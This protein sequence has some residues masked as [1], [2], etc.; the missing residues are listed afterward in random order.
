[1][2]SPIRYEYDA[3]VAEYRKIGFIPAV[4]LLGVLFGIGVAMPRTLQYFGV[5][6]QPQQAQLS[7]SEKKPVELAQPAVIENKGTAGPEI[8]DG[9]LESLLSQWEAAHPDKDWSVAVQRLGEKPTSAYL[10][11]D[12]QMEGASL[13]KL[14]L[15]KG[16]NEK[17]KFSQWG[18]TYVSGRTVKSCVEAMI[19]YSDNPCAVAISKMIDW[20][21]LDGRL[22]ALGMSGTEFNSDTPVVTARDTALLLQLLNDGQFLES[23]A[24]NLVL[25]SMYKQYYRKAIPAGVVGC[26]TYNKTGDLNG[27]KHDAAIVKCG[28][29]TYTVVIMSKGGTDAEL[30][31]LSKSINA[32]L[33]SRR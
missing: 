18:K 19:R 9:G 32:Y 26:E 14:F 22:Q 30:A 33:F 7:Q 2:N 25:T 4:L 10:N 15:L 24:E 29:L 31:E 8:V 21:Q 23:E 1:V 27:H 12:E 13:Y 5:Y 11:A 3:G 20:R 16:L 28:D 17:V 6:A